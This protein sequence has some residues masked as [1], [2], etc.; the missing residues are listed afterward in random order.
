[1]TSTTPSRARVTGIPALIVAIAG[2]AVLAG[3]PAAGPPIDYAAHA[4]FPDRWKQFGIDARLVPWEGERVVLLTTT[5][6][7]DAAAVGVFLARLDGGWK[8]YADAIGVA[9][10][11]R[12]L[13]AGKPTIAAVPDGRLTCGV[14]CGAVGATGVEVCGFATNDYPLVQ[15]DPRA[16]PHYYFY[17]L[18][19]NYYV[20]GDRHSSFITGFAVYMRYV[21]M[22]ALDCTDPEIDLR[23][24]IEAVEAK[25]AE[26]TM[27]FLRAFTMQGGLSE[28]EPRLENF[29]GPCDQPVMYASAM[30]KL[31]RDHGGDAWAGRFFRALMRCPEV[32]ATT[33]AGALAQSRAWLVAASVAARRDLSD[34]FCDRWRL[35][36]SPA[37]R[38]ALAK[39]DWAAP[40]IDAGK[41]LAGL[42]AE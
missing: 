42:P 20:F 1:M 27:D 24:S 41:I 31:Q 18:G 26:G 23:R 22:D 7:L 11:E 6:D 13:L 21:C 5:S 32:A 15:R 17:E 8:V 30:L 10:R 16:F 12:G 33:P 28:K 39:V 29:A 35:P 19:R 4:L 34:V 40:D 37:L 9:P 36:A 3:Q 38:E 2:A 25:H 14:G